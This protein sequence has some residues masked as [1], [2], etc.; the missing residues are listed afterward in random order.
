MLDLDDFKRVND[1]HGHAR[2]DV[3]L[4]AVG[5]AIDGTSR[6]GDL[7][8]RVG[9]DEF[10][11]LLPETESVDAAHVAQRTC[12]A[13]GT[14]GMGITASFGIA[15]WPEDG[16]SKEVLLAEADHRLYAMKRPATGQRF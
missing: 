2:G 10:A 16:G 4:A 5:E 12:E 1:E 8:F 14:V 15:A 9:G 11:M 7:V 6:A 13:I 3:V